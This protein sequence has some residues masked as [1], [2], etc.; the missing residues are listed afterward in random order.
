M[1][2]QPGFPGARDRVA[3]PFSAL[4]CGPDGAKMP[5]KG[6]EKAV[7]RSLPRG[8]YRRN[9]CIGIELSLQVLLTRAKGEIDVNYYSVLTCAENMARQT[10]A[11]SGKRSMS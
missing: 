7:S 11:G 4:I 5:R 2:S 6:V 3:L 1:G 8:S 10:F 9:S